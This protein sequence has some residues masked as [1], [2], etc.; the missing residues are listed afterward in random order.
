MKWRQSTAPNFLSLSLSRYNNA[1]KNRQ[2]NPSPPRTSIRCH[3]PNTSCRLHN[4]HPIRLRQNQLLATS[5]SAHDMETSKSFRV[6]KIPTKSSSSKQQRTPKI[7][8]EYRDTSHK[9]PWPSPR[10]ENHT[11]LWWCH[12]HSTMLEKANPHHRIGKGARV[13]KQSLCL[14][15]SAPQP[16][17]K[18]KQEATRVKWKHP[19]KV[20]EVIEVLEFEI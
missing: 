3:L 19:P 10:Q 13:E 5:L 7:L 17:Q 14:E 16:N 4:Q 12:S 11:E 20:F 9:K 6:P 2:A 15:G 1:S 18:M 8:A